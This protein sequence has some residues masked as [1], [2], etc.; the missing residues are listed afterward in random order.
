MHAEHPSSVFC[1]WLS[2]IFQMKLNLIQLILQQRFGISSIIELWPV[3]KVRYLTESIN[4]SG[5]IVLQLAK[6]FCAHSPTLIS[7]IV[8][9]WTIVS[10]TKINSDFY[11]ARL[12][13]HVSFQSTYCNNSWISRFFWISRKKVEFYYF[14]WTLF[15]TRNQQKLSMA[16]KKMF[17]NFLTFLYFQ[18]IRFQR[19]FQP[20]FRSSFEKLLF[21]LHFS[22]ISYILKPISKI[23]VNS[24]R[25]K[26]IQT[27]SPSIFV[28]FLLKMN[29]WLIC[30]SKGTICKLQTTNLFE[31]LKEIRS[32]RCD[33]FKKS[34]TSP[35]PIWLIFFS[36][37][38]LF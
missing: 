17:F 12:F 27:N 3:G 11:F 38:N 26:S 15:F 32:L 20:I 14:F 34:T 9:N 6:S 16:T 31:Y 30:T 24:I 5:A 33:E 36:F 2:A 29:K 7:C 22:Y 10:S 13:L 37:A 25:F 23:I 1:C 35:H 18:L 8:V 21:I 4:G 28:Y 19:L